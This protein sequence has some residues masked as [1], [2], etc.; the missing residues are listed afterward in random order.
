MEEFKIKL[1]QFNNVFSLNEDIKLSFSLQSN[2]KVLSEFDIRKVLDV[3]EVFNNERQDTDIYRIYGKIEYLSVLNNL[4]IDYSLLEDFFTIQPNFVPVKNI[5]NDFNFYLV[6]P[7][8]TFTGISTGTTGGTYVKNYEIISELGNF[9]I[10]NAGYSKNIYNEQQYSWNFNIDFDLTDDRDAF[11]FPIT[12]VC[13]FAQYK[14]SLNGLN[15]LEYMERLSFLSGQTVILSGVTATTYNVG[16]IVEGDLIYYQKNLFSQQTIQ[17]QEYYIY[18]PYSGIS[19]STVL[20]WKYYPFIPIT[21]KVYDDVI[22]R[23]NISGTSYDEIVRIPTY[24]TPIDGDGNHVWKILLDRGF[25][26]PLTGVGVNYPFVNGRQ[27]VFNNLILDIVPDLTHENTSQVF[28]EI[29]FAV[30]TFV[31]AQPSGELNDIGKPC[32]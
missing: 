18:T 17:R 4:K 7:S 19:G 15:E 31:D 3:T 20:K 12:E 24:A 28:S 23:L 21:L 1:G 6:K 8:R 14:P 11:N 30:D 27:Y 22:Q 10:Y 13:L 16:D 26:D 32:I 2:K 29:K 9:E 25:V 5:F